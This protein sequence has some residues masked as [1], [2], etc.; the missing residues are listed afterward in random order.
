MNL[1]NEIVV[2]TIHEPAWLPGY[3]DNLRR[4]GH[5]ATTRISI[6]ADRKTPASVFAAAVAARQQ[7]YHLWCPTLDEQERFLN[8]LGA[9]AD[10]IPWDSDNRRNLGFLAAQQRGAGLLISID[11]DNYC[12]A[13][14]DFV[15]GHQALFR[16]PDGSEQLAG[17]AAWFNLC[18]RLEHSSAT[19]IF[20]RGFPYA[21]RTKAGAT[22]AALSA[23][24]PG[25]Q[26]LNA[27]LWLDD[28][29][30]D[31]VT[32]LSLAPRAREVRAGAVL[33]ASETWSPINTQNTAVI[34]EAIPAW[35]YPRMGD[36]VQGLRI[37]RYGDILSGYLVQ[38]CIKHLGQGLR[39]GSPVAVHRR[40]PHNLFKDLYCE[41]AGMVLVEDLL[42]WLQELRIS[43]SS[44]SEAY[45]AL[46]DALA[47]EAQHFR[48]FIW[49]EGG[50]EFLVK[51]AQRM[52]TW[53]RLVAL[54]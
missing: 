30:V 19:P 10:F 47:E 38:K 21:A 25:R 11:D 42:P 16:A 29:D 48:G 20:P 52:Q 35:Y 49:D 37:D 43:G 3:L 14:E 44:Y 5:D 6:I 39:I 53:L 24:T 9:P 41:L 13:E 26:A 1:P 4:Y 27:G 40:S 28:P 51:T 31:A 23:Q 17:G 36:A 34:A 2:T 33:L 7:G 54:V 15:G 8:G 32:R 46:A 18:S 50:R 22:L 12:P 45:A